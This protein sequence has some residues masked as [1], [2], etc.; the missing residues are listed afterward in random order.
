MVDS[1]HTDIALSDSLPHEAYQIS[2][3]IHNFTAAHTE[4]FNNYGPKPNSELI[5]GYGFSLP[6]N[7]DDTIVLSIGGRPEIG[8][9]SGRTWEVGRDARGSEGLWVEMTVIFAQASYDGETT[10][11][12]WELELEAA[13]TLKEMVARKLLL[14]PYAMEGVQ[15]GVRGDVLQMIQHYI[16][17]R[18][19]LNQSVSLSQFLFL[20]FNRSERYST[21]TVC[22]CRFETRMCSHKGE[23]GWGGAYVRR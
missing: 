4:V 1:I 17:G 23:G 9:S 10:P 14:L 3:I 18:S 16:E 2:L 7:P 6:V 22:I 11:A 5:L 15:E 12:E 20:L 13:E 19:Y 8:D 21:V